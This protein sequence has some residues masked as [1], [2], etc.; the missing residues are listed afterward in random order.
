MTNF[1]TRYQH[2]PWAVTEFFF[3]LY[4][5][6]FFVFAGATKIP[7]LAK[8]QQD[9][10]NYHLVPHL[11]AGMIA[12]F[13]PWF[14]IACGT[15]LLIRKL[16]FGALAATTAMMAVFTIGFLQ[17]QIRGIDISCG[18]F[19]KLSEGFPAW[20]IITRDVVLLSSLGFMWW[21]SLKKVPSEIEAEYKQSNTS[22]EKPLDSISTKDTVNA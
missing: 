1:L 12:I 20:V 2:K 3:R 22:P 17:A 5:A 21:V 4:I 15:A 6:A 19:G 16:Y 18:C 9:V 8:F 10:L 13:L 11:I 7:D 14:E